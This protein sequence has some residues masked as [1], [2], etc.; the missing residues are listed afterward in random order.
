[1]K[2]PT[3]PPIISTPQAPTAL[4]AGAT[5][6][7]APHHTGWRD[8]IPCIGRGVCVLA[9]P[10]AAVAAPHI[11]SAK[12]A[13][14]LPAT[15]HL[16]VHSHTVRA[17][18]LEVPAY[19]RTPDLD[20]PTPY[21]YLETAMATS[22]HLHHAAGFPSYHT[23][24]MSAAG[25]ANSNSSSA[26]AAGANYRNPSPYQHQQQ[27]QQ[28]SADFFTAEMRDRQARGKD[29]YRDSDSDSDDRTSA[30]YAAHGRTTR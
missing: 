30:D 26:A 18:T 22:H 8:Q 20:L 12:R 27:Q 7:P 24:M 2:A 3:S 15:W 14:P 4:F 16:L 29:P 21:L 17:P 13:C 9:E 11:A 25:G 6:T 19:L 10:T 5:G 28:Q 1:M 23:T